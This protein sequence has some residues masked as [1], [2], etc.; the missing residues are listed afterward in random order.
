MNERPILS[1]VFYELVMNDG[2][3]PLVRFQNINQINAIVLTSE[4]IFITKM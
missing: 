3:H 1:V 2:F 4:I